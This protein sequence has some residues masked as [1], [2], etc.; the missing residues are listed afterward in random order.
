MF[1]HI[2]RLVVARS[3]TSTSHN[4]SNVTIPRQTQINRTNFLKWES[5]PID[6]P[7]TGSQIHRTKT[8][9]TRTPEPFQ[10]INTANSRV[11]RP[12]P[13]WEDQWTFSMVS[14]NPSTTSALQNTTSLSYGYPTLQVAMMVARATHNKISP[15]DSVDH[16]VLF[17]SDSLGFL[18]Y[19]YT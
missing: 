5:P 7:N 16:L 15:S 13:Q 6:S 14:D 2:N 8:S 12:T 18:I 11:T 4:V 3:T 10:N 19:M 9:K 17:P 1:N